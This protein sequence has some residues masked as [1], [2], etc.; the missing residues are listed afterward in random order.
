MIYNHNDRIVF[1]AKITSNTEANVFVVPYGLGIRF[2]LTKLYIYNDAG[3]ATTVKIFDHVATGTVTDPPAQGD[4]TSPL[5]YWNIPTVSYI[6]EGDDKL[7]RITFQQGMAIVA[8]Q[9]SV[10]V[11][12]TVVEA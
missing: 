1:R 5:L 9:G 12:A 6:A 3:T 11:E 8:S 2:K 10:Y 7:P 4:A